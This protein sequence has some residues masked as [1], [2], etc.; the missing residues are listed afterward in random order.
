MQAVWGDYNCPDSDAS[1]RR[2]AAMR[3][4]VCG[5]QLHGDFVQRLELISGQHVLDCN[6]CGKC[7]AG[8]PVASAM[9]MLP[10]QVIRLVQLG[11]DEAL[12]CQAIWVCASCFTCVTRCPKGVD[13][14]RI[15]EALRQIH[16]RRRRRTAL[17]RRPLPA[18][19]PGRAAGHGG[20][21]LRG[22]HAK[23][24]SGWQ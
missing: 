16:L 15:M 12:D 7:S 21:D 17:S 19:S 8:C 13:L 22:V 6:Q 2:G 24:S 23:M 11:L 10:S 3:T 9:D 14:S 1:G 4:T 5:E 20:L 18:R